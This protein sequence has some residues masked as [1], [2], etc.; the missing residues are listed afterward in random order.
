MSAGDP[1]SLFVFGS[2]STA[3]EVY[4]VAKAVFP[5]RTIRLVQAQGESIE[6]PHVISEDALKAAADEQPGDHGFI[7]P[8]STQGFRARWLQTASD[9]GLQ[10]ES[11]I[12]P[13]AVIAEGASLGP[14]CYLAAN[15]VVSNNASLAGHCVINY[16]VVIGHDASLSE[17]VI[18]NPGASIGGCSSIGKRVLIGAN[19]FIAQNLSIGDDC[20][21][22]A[23]TYVD[24]DLPPNAIVSS[25]NARIKPRPEK[26]ASEGTKRRTYH[27]VALLNVINRIRKNGNHQPIA[28][29]EEDTRLREDL[30]MDSLT[31]AELAVNLEAEFGVDVFAHGLV[32]TVAEIETRLGA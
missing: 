22:D 9:L 29:L 1:S 15:A 6:A 18:V 19:A 24:A 25:R 16:N 21:V 10:A 28:S 32:F 14:G 7:I 3:E 12:H 27:R 30:G 26:P 5:G 31:L 8:M 13:S 11:V 17:H 20:S 23:L 2:R 4:F